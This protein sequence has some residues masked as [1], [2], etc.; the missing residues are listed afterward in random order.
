MLCRLSTIGP[1][2]LKPAIEGSICSVSGSQWMPF[3]RRPIT[4]G[5]STLSSTT[6][7]KDHTEGGKVRHFQRESSEEH[8]PMRF[9]LPPIQSKQSLDRRVGHSKQVRSARL[10]QC[11]S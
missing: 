10:Q 6:L 4:E 7:M 8:S 1:R 5:R 3:V 2:H 9:T 11:I